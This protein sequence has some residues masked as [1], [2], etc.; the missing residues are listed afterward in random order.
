MAT[1]PDW[2]PKR[3]SVAGRRLVNFGATPAERRRGLALL[4]AAAAQG[5]A[6]AYAW[7]GSAYDLGWGVR[8]DAK[9]AF[10]F[11]LKGEELG[12]P[13]AVY[14]V[15]AFY[16]MGNGVRRDDGMAVKWARRS[17]SLG[18]RAGTYL[19]GICYRYGRG[20]TRNH[21]RG[22]Q[23]LMEAAQDG[24]ADAQFS[25]GVCFRRGECV[26]EDPQAAFEWFMKAARRGHRDAAQRLAVLR[27]GYR[28]EGEPSQGSRV[29]RTLV[30]TRLNG[31]E[32]ERAALLRSHETGSH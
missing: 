18:F 5:Q 13:N 2:S 24:E 1:V 30:E 25:V 10:H 29:G 27:A 23:L 28:R 22:F 16:Y 14:H 17:R 21:R 31:F 6:A 20:V 19:L 3:L 11:Y 12:E 8:R 15:G 32:D 4:E 9:R 26:S 7:L